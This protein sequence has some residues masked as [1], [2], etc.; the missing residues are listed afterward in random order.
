MKTVVKSLTNK[1]ITNKSTKKPLFVSISKEIDI[2]KLTEKDIEALY[3]TGL[4]S[5]K[6]YKE[7]KALKEI[8]K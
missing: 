2:D 3:K 8:K 4:E 5:K 7:Y 1:S 6:K